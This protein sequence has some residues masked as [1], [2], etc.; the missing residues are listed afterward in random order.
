[1]ESP[2]AQLRRN[3]IGTTIKLECPTASLVAE[4]SHTVSAIICRSQRR[5]YQQRQL[6]KS[7]VSEVFLLGRR[8]S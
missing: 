6:G 4:I 8:Q 3:T 1:M 2:T 7:G 5:A